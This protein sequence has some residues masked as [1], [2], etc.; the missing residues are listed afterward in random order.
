MASFFKA[1]MK[2]R[3]IEWDKLCPGFG[4]RFNMDGSKMFVARLSVRGRLKA[5]TIA[6]IDLIATDD[7]RKL[8]QRMKLLARAGEDPYSILES[9]LKGA[10][11]EN[12]GSGISF[13]AYS[14]LYIDDYAK[15]YKTS[16]LKD[17]QRIDRY[18]MEDW[19]SR[20]LN[21]IK[22][23]DFLKI[24]K[25]I[26]KEH[27][28][29]ANRLKETVTTLFKEAIVSGHL[30]KNF[31][32]PTAGIKHHK[33][34][35]RR[36]KVDIKHMPRLLKAIHAHPEEV[37]K[38]ALLLI[39]YLGLRTGECIRMR[40]DWFDFEAGVLEIPGWTVENKVRVKITKTGEP[41]RVPISNSLARLVNSYKRQPGNPYLFPSPIRSKNRIARLDKA[42]E[43]IRK[44]AGFSTI[45]VHDLRRTFGCMILKQTSSQAMVR[46]LLNH[47]DEHISAVY[48]YYE[49][50]DMLP[51]LE[52]HG[53]L[54]ERLLGT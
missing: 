50:D 7:A 24:F 54:I 18:L 6:P 47:S 15:V 34:M 43:K 51:V 32:L 4:V 27:K 23:Q 8:V 19:G 10:G 14:D 2:K 39:I 17:R 21:S 45:T 5:Y 52:Q 44:K 49:T 53:E 11:I 3:E 35:P 31:E 29:A 30:P 16:W 25:E 28:V 33:E 12:V 13:K 41:H 40:W 38:N 48:S 9:F 46:D 37:Y 36:S 22:Y 20:P 42:W 26:S 1:Q